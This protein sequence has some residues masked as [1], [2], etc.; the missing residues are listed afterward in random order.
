[1]KKGN[2]LLAAVLALI[3]C[4]GSA[5]I[6]YRHRENLGRIF[7]TGGEIGLLSAFK[8]DHLAK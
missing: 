4:L 8:G 5:V 2:K 1:M 7:I 6:L 3:L